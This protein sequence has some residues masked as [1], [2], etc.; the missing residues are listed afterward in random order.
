MDYYKELIVIKK[1]IQLSKLLIQN[2]EILK[3]KAKDYNLFIH[4]IASAKIYKDYN[5]MEFLYTYFFWKNY[6]K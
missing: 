6:I 4:N 2:K 3:W 5:A 1:Y